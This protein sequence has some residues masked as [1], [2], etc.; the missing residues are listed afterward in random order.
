MFSPSSGTGDATVDAVG[1]ANREVPLLIGFLSEATGLESDK[2]NATLNDKF[3]HTAALLAALPLNLATG[4]LVDMLTDLG[5]QLDMSRD[6]LG[7]AL[8]ENFPNLTAAITYLP[9]AVDQFRAIPGLDTLTNFSGEPV[10]TVPELNDFFGDDLVPVLERQ[11]KNFAQLRDYLPPVSIFPPLLTALGV[12]LLLLGVTMALRTQAGRTRGRAAGAGI[13]MVSGIALIG[14]VLGARMFPALNGGDDMVEDFR[15]VYADNRIEDYPAAVTMA[16]NFV[17]MATPITDPAGGAADE[18]PKLFAFLG[19]KLEIQP[20]KLQK[21]IGSRYPH[22]TAL[23]TAIP[24]SAVIDEQKPLNN[25]LA[26]TLN[27]TPEQVTQV[28]GDEFPR[29]TVATVTLAD[30]VARWNDLAGPSDG[31]TRFDGTPI[32][33]M[34]EWQ[35]YLQRDL[36]PMLISQRANFDDLDSGPPLKIFPPLLLGTGIFLLILGFTLT[37]ER[38]QSSPADPR[39]RSATPATTP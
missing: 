14:I 12:L 3:P 33:T 18:V 31:Y 29:I 9:P 8:A 17:R 22:V 15:L 4:E 38:R 21:Q 36:V 30:H 28:M 2:V 1:G 26:T 39:H 19:E 6:E 13:V 35:Q 5:Q 11:Q 34:L 7:A 16:G 32:N 27:R 10:H 37:R 23:L 25:F 24:F 20:E